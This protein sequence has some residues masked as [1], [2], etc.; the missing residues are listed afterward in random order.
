VTKRT[1]VRR[2]EEPIAPVT[3]VEVKGKPCG[4]KKGHISFRADDVFKGTLAEYM[5]SHGL[6]DKSK[7]IR[8]LI[9]KGMQG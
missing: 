7:A 9:E 4:T 8:A 1:K 2:M 3:L 5:T 6:N